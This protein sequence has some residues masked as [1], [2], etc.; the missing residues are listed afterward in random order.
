MA[1]ETHPEIREAVRRLCSQFP[2]PYWRAKDRDRSYPTEFVTA[3]TEAGFL[4]VLIPESYVADLDAR[5][6]LYRRLGDIES[7]ADIDGFAAELIDRFGPLPGEVDHLLNVV[8]LKGMCRQ[9]GIAKLDAGPKG[10]IISFRGNAP[11]NPMG[12][13]DWVRK[14]A[15]VAKLRNDHKLVYFESD[16][17]AELRVKITRDLLADL[18]AIASA[19]EGAGLAKKGSKP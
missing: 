2:G 19:G 14:H 15:D 10:L 11:P 8:E 9:A 12:I 18:V 16:E 3:L 1:S 7:R 5:L 13:I 17:S 4:S 6:S